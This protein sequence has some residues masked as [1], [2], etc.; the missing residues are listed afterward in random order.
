MNVMRSPL[1][2]EHKSVSARTGEG[3]VLV[4]TVT[5]GFATALERDTFIYLDLA[6]AKALILELAR[7][8]ATN[9][10][11]DERPDVDF[12]AAAILEEMAENL[13]D[14]AIARSM[15]RRK[16]ART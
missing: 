13:G 4:G 11:T 6:Q 7:H 3:A 10:P 2:I 14:E 12:S 1:T 5:S 15:Q 16:E 9:G 8:L